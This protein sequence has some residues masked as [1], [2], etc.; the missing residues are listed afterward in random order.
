MVLA[1][2]TVA[3]MAAR[4][5]DDPAEDELPLGFLEFLGGMVEVDSATGP[6]LLDPL[7]LQEL[8][9]AQQPAQQE[10]GAP[11]SEQPEPAKEVS[12]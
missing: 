9:E 10:W 2:L 11:A 6:R 12:P 1:V 7:D 8:M 5:A 4:S 3:A